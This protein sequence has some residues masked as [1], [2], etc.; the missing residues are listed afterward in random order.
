MQVASLIPPVL[1][2]AIG[3]QLGNGTE[4]LEQFVLRDLAASLIG[5]IAKKYSHSSH[6]LKP[7]LARTFL[8]NFLD[9]GKPFGTHYGAII[10]LHAI[11]GADVIRELVLPNLPIYE[12]VLKDA[13]SDEGLR[14]LESEK[15]IDVLLA[16][17]KTL[18]DR[19]LPTMNGHSTEITEAREQQLAAKVGEVLAARIVESGQIRLVN[20][21]LQTR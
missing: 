14:K 15:V 18:E 6:T 9:P 4:P 11:G 3:R 2:C 8:K 19:K 13:S 5:M 21:I 20:A 7:R 10:G 1:T 16:V 12:I 17:L